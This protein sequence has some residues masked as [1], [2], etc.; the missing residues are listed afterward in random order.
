MNPVDTCK[1]KTTIDL[2]TLNFLIFCFRIFIADVIKRNIAWPFHG[3][4]ILNPVSN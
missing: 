3:V 1:R 4:C 2:V